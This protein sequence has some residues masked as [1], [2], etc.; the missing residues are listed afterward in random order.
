MDERRDR[1]GRE[2]EESFMK[3][4]NSEASSQ[5]ILEM[6]HKGKASS[7]L[8]RTYLKPEALFSYLQRLTLC[9]PVKELNNLKLPRS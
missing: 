1:L 7:L 2:Q 6:Q 8:F 3:V 4:S 5:L 9:C